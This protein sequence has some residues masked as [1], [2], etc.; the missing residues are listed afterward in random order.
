M[1]AKVDA[2]TIVERAVD[3]ALQD[4][5]KYASNEFKE[6][7]TADPVKKEELKKAAK[8]AAEEKVKLAAELGS[9]DERTA[10]DIA[11]L[12]STHY[13]SDRLELIETGLQV[14]TYKLDI[15]K[16]SDGYHWVHIT[17]DEENFMDPIRLDSIASTN[18]AS[19]IQIA[20][21]VVESVLLV[22]QAVGIKLT[23]DKKII[24]K[25][26]RAII[27]ILNKS[28]A[29]QNDVQALIEAVA[30]GSTLKMATAIFNLIKDLFSAGILWQIIKDLCSNMST[31]EWIQTALIVTTVIIA[32]MISGGA[33]LIVEIAFALK[34]AYD[35]LKKFKN[36]SEIQAVAANF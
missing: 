9:K 26:A 1:T 21:I 22:L 19:D 25:T 27:T 34:S 20:S 30:T 15:G 12:L 11:K 7:L 35:F 31:L 29:I 16:K 4:V 6:I 5:E 17:R 23:G 3:A 36:L 18:T 13:S 24:L 28:S 32:D 8:E 14:P 2:A 33:A 10:E